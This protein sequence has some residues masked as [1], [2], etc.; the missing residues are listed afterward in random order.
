MSFLLLFE[1]ELRFHDLE[2]K[3]DP[4]KIMD[5]QAELCEIQL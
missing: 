3:M 4:F 5:P 1:G 2:F